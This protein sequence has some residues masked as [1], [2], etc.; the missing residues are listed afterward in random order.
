MK[1]DESGSLSEADTLKLYEILY[2]VAA[3]ELQVIRK[4]YEG[5]RRSL[6]SELQAEKY[7]AV[8]LQQI[9][10]EEKLFEKVTQK[11]ALEVLQVSQ[12]ELRALQENNAHKASV[13]KLVLKLHLQQQ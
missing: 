4:E 11:L 10:D 1:K 13:Q 12:E 5:K 3:P 6:L 2:T 8:A 7:K 9:A